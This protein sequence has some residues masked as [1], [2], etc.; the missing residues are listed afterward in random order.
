MSVST[1]VIRAK[2]VE[3]SAHDTPA[4]VVWV[5]SGSEQQYSRIQLGM[6]C[7]ANSL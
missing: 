3:L 6:E 7:A 5:C 4:F 1:E 2:V